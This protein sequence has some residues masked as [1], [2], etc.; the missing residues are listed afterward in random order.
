MAINQMT[1]ARWEA[2]GWVAPEGALGVRSV[3]DEEAWSP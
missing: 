2:G 1:W 3:I